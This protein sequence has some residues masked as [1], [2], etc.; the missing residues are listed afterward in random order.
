M[1]HVMN[2]HL[3][4]LTQCMHSSKPYNLILNIW[5]TSAS[6]ELDPAANI[7]EGGIKQCFFLYELVSN[8]VGIEYT[9][10]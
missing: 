5:S 2:V 3:G 6:A 8:L 10:V 1:A 7:T 4:R 9:I